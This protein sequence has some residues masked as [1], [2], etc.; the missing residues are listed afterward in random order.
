MSLFGEPFTAKCLKSQKT[1]EVEEGQS[2]LQ[3][4]LDAGIDMDYSCEGG[5]CGTCVVPLVSGEV[6]HQDEFLMDDEH[7]THMTTC[8]SRGIGEIEIDV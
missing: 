1:V 4:L 2:L 7:E 5:V 3:A 8:V 6:D